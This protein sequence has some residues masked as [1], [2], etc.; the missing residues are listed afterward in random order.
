MILIGTN[1]LGSGMSPEM[2]FQGVKAVVAMVRLRRPL[3]HVLLLGIL[4]RSDNL[5]RLGQTPHTTLSHIQTI[6]QRL[7]EEVAG[8]RGDGTILGG[9][10][11]SS[12]VPPSE[13]ENAAKDD[14]V[15]FLDCGRSFI[16]SDGSL[17]VD[18]MP[19]LLH[20]NAAGAEVWVQC[21]KPTIE[22]MLKLRR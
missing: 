8:R 5:K 20:P 10:S 4:P 19:D 18:L 1:N 16:S 3:V 17:K 11:E 7:E 14:M 21:M 15:W 12:A 2:A 9:S 13:K 6:N 22:H